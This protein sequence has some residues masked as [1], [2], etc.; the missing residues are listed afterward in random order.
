MKKRLLLTLGLLLCLGLSVPAHAAPTVTNAGSANAF[1]ESYQHISQ[2][3]FRVTTWYVGVYSSA[4]GAFSDVYKDVALCTDRDDEESGCVSES[5]SY[6]AT[7]LSSAQFTIDPIMLE[8]AHLEAVYQMQSYDTEG[9]P[10][11]APVATP[12]VADWTGDGTTERD[13]GASVYSSGCTVYVGAYAGASRNAEAS[14]SFGS[15]DLGE[16]YGANLGSFLATDVVE[17]C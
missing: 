8:S 2:G 5:S 10:I 3:K 16:T 15:H 6:G 17:S 14:G 1:W 9:N 4:E 12:V 7:E 13:R 11:G